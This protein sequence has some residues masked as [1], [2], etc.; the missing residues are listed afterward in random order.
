MIKH[1]CLY[2]LCLVCLFSCVQPVI[3]KKE[4]ALPPQAKEIMP[5]KKMVHI[6]Y[7]PSKTR[8]LPEITALFVEYPLAAMT[9]GFPNAKYPRLVRRDPPKVAKIGHGPLTHSNHVGLQGKKRE[10]I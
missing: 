9:L 2:L 7:L 1:S 10:G 4:P 3:K 5:A 8:S 6:I